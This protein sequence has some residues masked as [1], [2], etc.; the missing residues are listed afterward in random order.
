MKVLGKIASVISKEIGIAVLV[1]VAI[2]YDIQLATELTEKLV[3][4]ALSGVAFM[5]VLAGLCFSMAQFEENGQHKKQ[6]AIAGEKLFHAC[7]LYVEAIF[8]RY[9]LDRLILMPM[10]RNSPNSIGVVVD[11]SVVLVVLLS[12]YGTYFF[13]Y[14][15][16][17]LNNIFWLRYEK[18][19]EQ[20]G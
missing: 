10:L 5:A 9:A 12:I 3:P 18:R 11:V 8:I 2:I 7:I 16:R 19:N 1:V 13:L 20:K 4:F 14:G 15:F 17:M 6:I